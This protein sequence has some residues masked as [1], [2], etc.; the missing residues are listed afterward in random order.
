V[1]DRELASQA[2]DEIEADRE[3]DID[4]DEVDDA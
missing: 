4:A 1:T 3:G 2:V